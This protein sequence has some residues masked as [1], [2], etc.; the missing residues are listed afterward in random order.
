MSFENNYAAYL[1]KLEDA[2]KAHYLA[3]DPRDLRFSNGVLSAAEAG[4][5]DGAAGELRMLLEKTLAGKLSSGH[6]FLEHP[7]VRRIELPGQREIAIAIVNNQSRD[8]YGSEHTIEAFDFLLEARRGVFKDC[9]R[10]LDLGGHQ[11][12]WTSFYAMTGPDSHVVSYEPSILNVAIGLFN[13]LVNGVVERVDVVPFAALASNATAGE[14]DHAK[15]L[16][17]FMT[18]P[19]RA[20]SIEERADAPFDFIKTD[21]EGYE[22]ELLNDPVYLDLL[23]RAKSTHLE[24]HLGHLVGQGVRLQQWVDRLQDANL[25]GTELYTQVDMYE[26]LSHCDS[27]GFHSFLVK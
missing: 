2:S 13:C 3:V 18:V 9:R 27:Q 1:R 17:D 24:L 14:G 7:Y 16:V 25:Q 6:Q 15:M 8:W 5:W 12:V 20:R 23:S 4:N 22:F 11:L 21:I 26:F 19:L 10:F